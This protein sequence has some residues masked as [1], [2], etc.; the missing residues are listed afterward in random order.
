MA[1]ACAAAT[2]SGVVPSAAAAEPDL[3]RIR[4]R[5][6]DDAAAVAAALLGAQERLRVVVC[7]HL[8]DDYSDAGGQP[9]RD[10]L[11]PFAM[12]PADYLALLVI[13]DGGERGAGRLCRTRGVAA[14]TEPNGRVVY[15]CGAA[16][17]ELS[18]AHRENV[19]IHEMLHSLGLGEGPP[20]SAEINAAVWRRCGAAR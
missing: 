12:E 13:V 17:R 10:K 5:S 16:F 6:A 19:L 8:L 18:E 20:S 7:Q 9:L 3:R 2:V 11:V 4:V 1:V 14:V 15:V